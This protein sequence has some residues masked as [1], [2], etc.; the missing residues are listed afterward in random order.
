MAGPSIRFNEVVR[1]LT[2][3]HDVPVEDVVTTGVESVSSITLQ[4]VSRR[5]VQPLSYGIDEE[6]HNPDLEDQVRRARIE[7]SRESIAEIRRAR[8]KE[9][10]QEECQAAFQVSL[11]VWLALAL[12]CTIA[13]LR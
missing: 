5:P 7:A 11:G 1:I 4:E 9:Q 2:I 3:E 13:D 10:E 6:R 8:R 12:A